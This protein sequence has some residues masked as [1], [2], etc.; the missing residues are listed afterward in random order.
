MK[1]L[2]AAAAVA[3]LFAVTP[4]ALDE[5]V[6]GVGGLHPIRPFPSA[7]TE[8][9][10]TSRHAIDFA[11]GTWWAARRGP[12]IGWS[13]SFPAPLDLRGVHVDVGNY[14][15]WAA[16]AEDLNFS[17]NGGPLHV[18]HAER[19]TLYLQWLR[20]DF[21]PVATRTLRISAAPLHDNPGA[22]W[23]LFDVRF[24]VSRAYVLDASAYVASLPGLA[25]PLVAALAWLLYLRG[26]ARRA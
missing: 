5:R 4:L 11:P 2:A 25:A 12:G 8:S 21:A 18:P 22:K 6:C 10:E 26:R 17:F 1:A 19:E 14:H 3:V 9:P 13:V 24:R 16:R 15:G 20:F 23:S 7:A